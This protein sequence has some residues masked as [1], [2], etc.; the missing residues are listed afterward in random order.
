MRRKK[1]NPKSR[2]NMKRYDSD[3]SSREDAQG[4]PYLLE[5]NKGEVD[6]GDD[7]RFEEFAITYK[8]VRKNLQFT[9]IGR[10]QKKV[11]QSDKKGKKGKSKGSQK[12]K[13]PFRPRM[14]PFKGKFPK[15]SQ[16]YNGGFTKKTIFKQKVEKGTGKKVKASE[17]RSRVKCYNC[18]GFWPFLPGSQNKPPGG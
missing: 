15:D 5:P 10:D 1:R 17:L 18:G 6:E 16:R 7:N 13:K 12:G 9:C 2:V 3:G 11:D 4:E 8:A 14:Q